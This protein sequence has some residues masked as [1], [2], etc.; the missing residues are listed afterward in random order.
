MHCLGIIPNVSINN[1]LPL[2]INN[3]KKT[4]K[5][6]IFSALFQFWTFGLIPSLEYF[7]LYSSFENSKIQHKNSALFS[8]PTVS[9]GDGAVLTAPHWVGIKLKNITIGTNCIL[10]NQI[11]N[12]NSQITSER[13]DS[14]K[15]KKFKSI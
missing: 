5:S 4:P 2:E 1:Y 7:R 9:T 13:Q 15:C 10:A 14:R 3:I 11:R 12:V 8:H 6:R